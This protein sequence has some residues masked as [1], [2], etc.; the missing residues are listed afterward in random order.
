MRYDVMCNH[1]RYHRCRLQSKLSSLLLGELSCCTKAGPPGSGKTLLA[2][3]CAAEAGW[4]GCARYQ[5]R[6]S[7]MYAETTSCQLYPFIMDCWR[8]AWHFSMSPQQS[9][10][11]LG[12][13]IFFFWFSSVFT[14]GILKWRR[15]SQISC[16]MSCCIFAKE[17]FVGRGAARVRQERG[18]VASSVFWY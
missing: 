15:C 9:L 1:C 7:G 11:Q 14:A 8:P 13:S 5:V 17:L 16:T 18:T 6:F 2:R 3:A 10:W 12:C 4:E